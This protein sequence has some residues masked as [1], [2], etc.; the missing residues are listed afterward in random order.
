MTVIFNALLATSNDDD[1]DVAHA[2][3]KVPASA[4]ASV[5]QCLPVTA[6][7][8]LS[9]APRTLHPVGM[10]YVKYSTQFFN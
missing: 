10:P 3:V 4:Q 6:D 8:T 7:V 9:P 1:V 2:H 5:A